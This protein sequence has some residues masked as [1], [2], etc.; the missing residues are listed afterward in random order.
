MNRNGRF[1]SILLVLSR[2]LARGWELVDG[3]RVPQWHGIHDRMEIGL[4]REG[5]GQ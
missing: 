5:Q 1:D 3:I 2:E 4:R